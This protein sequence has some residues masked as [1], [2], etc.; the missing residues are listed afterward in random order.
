MRIILTIAFSG[1]VMLCQ[2][3]NAVRD[4]EKYLDDIRKQPYLSLP[5]SILE[6]RKSENKQLKLLKSS[7]SDSLNIVRGRSYYLIK[8]IGKR[9][10]DVSLRQAAVV[11]L[12]EGIADK[13]TGISGS[14]SEALKGFEKKDFTNE[15]KLMLVQFLK[16]GTPHLNQLIRLI[17]FLDLKDQQSKLTE[18][19]NSKAPANDKW[20]CHL[21]LARM[22]EESSINFIIDKVK[23]TAVDDKLVYGIVP[24]L[25]YTKQK[26]IFDYLVTIINLDTPSC[27]SANPDS[28]E[29]ILCGY[30]VMEHVAND[31]KEFPVAVDDFGDLKTND[32]KKALTDVRQWFSAHPDYE[33]DM[34][35]Y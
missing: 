6:D 27:Q 15:A 29:K 25:T 34:S 14:N 31:I 3:Q 17:G 2:S 24:D 22:G 10:D 8:V 13:D 12:I 1:I 30:R 26:A 33:I 21:A 23:S 16:P 35:T 5:K 18:M 28:N 9:S 4:L 32:Y 20:A 7:T 19:I 11:A